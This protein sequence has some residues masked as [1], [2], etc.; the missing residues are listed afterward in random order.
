LRSRGLV[1]ALPTACATM[2]S[3]IERGAGIGQKQGDSRMPCLDNAWL[4]PNLLLPEGEEASEGLKFTGVCAVA[5]PPRH[6]L[7]PLPNFSDGS[8][9]PSDHC[10]VYFDLAFHDVGCSTPPP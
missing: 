9:C 8:G 10:P 5:I 4:S 7:I 1:C 3:A 6:P 2:T